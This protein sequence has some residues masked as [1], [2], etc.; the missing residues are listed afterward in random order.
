MPRLLRG[1]YGD[2]TPR[3]PDHLHRLVACE[4]FGRDGL[5]GC[6]DVESGAGDINLW[7]H[8]VKY[9][10]IIR[11]E[12]AGVGVPERGVSVL[13]LNELQFGAVAEV[14]KA[15]LGKLVAAGVA[16]ALDILA[17]KDGLYVFEVIEHAGFHGHNLICFT[18]GWVGTS[19]RDA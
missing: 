5:Y 7:W 8:A 17:D 11:Y 3:N 1:R 6:R 14:E 13:N 10:G 16:D 4:G 15:A 18:V 2:E 9:F 19:Q 12:S